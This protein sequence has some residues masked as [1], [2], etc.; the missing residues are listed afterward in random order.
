MYFY[1]FLL[2]CTGIKESA[3]V[4]IKYLGKMY[5]VVSIHCFQ[6]SHETKMTETTFMKPRFT[7][8]CALLYLSLQR[9]SRTAENLATAWIKR[10][11]RATFVHAHTAKNQSHAHTQKL[12]LRS[13][14]SLQTGE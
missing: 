8:I 10:R 5:F 4:N 12:K 1:F 13:Q 2:Y 7:M 9:E 14:W 6:L 3:L 11:F